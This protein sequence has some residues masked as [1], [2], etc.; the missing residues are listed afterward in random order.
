[1]TEE[2]YVP[3]P[4]D[5]SHIKLDE[6][7]PLLEKL[8][9][10]AHEVWAQ[11]RIE[12]GWT[13]G[14]RRDDAKRKHPCLIPYDELPDSE[15]E[16]DRALVN[17]TLKTTLALKYRIVKLE[18]RPA[19]KLPR[20]DSPHDDMDDS[21]DIS[22]YSKEV[23]AGHQQF[24]PLLKALLLCRELIFP[25]FQTADQQAKNYRKEYQGTSQA[26]VW[27]GVIAIFLGLYETVFPNWSPVWVEYLEFSFALLCMASIL[28]GVLRKPK[29]HWLLARYRAENLRLLKFKTLMDTRV[30]CDDSGETDRSGEV[31]SDHVREQV[32]A[33]ILTLRA[34][35]Y[36]DVEERTVDGVVPDVS[37][38][39]CSETSPKSLQEIIK[40]YCDKRIRAQMYYL[41]EAGKNDGAGPHL[42][43]SIIFFLSFGCILLHSGLDLLAYSGIEVL[44]TAAV[45]GP[46]VVAGI[47]TYLASREFARNAL[48]HRATLHSLQALN[49]DMVKAASLSEKFR[50][51]R[52]CEL[53]L[54]FDSSE[55]MR[56]LRE[57]EWYG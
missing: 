15:K 53:I 27:F 35:V 14:P 12:D 34:M 9:R 38:I 37:D 49:E 33:K 8:A 13:L 29:E 30:W 20:D 48:R 23:E 5:T 32:V 45:L 57:V 6:L 28:V 54:E 11:K 50:I 40:Y 26:A 21:A 46:A 36:E 55:F 4:I 17:Q 16:Y 44:I 31:P 3:H 1:M 7:R 43:M 18:T 42:V 19:Q 51:A 22:K 2:P 56:L 25:E 47:K 52:S 39:Q 10:N 41:A 24:L